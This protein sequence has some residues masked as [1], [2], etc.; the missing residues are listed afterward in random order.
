MLASRSIA[1]YVVLTRICSFNA[2]KLHLVGSIQCALVP[3][4]LKYDMHEAA[5]LERSRP[6]GTETV[7]L[8]LCSSSMI[9]QYH[10]RACFPST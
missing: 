10:W 3:V 5:C 8:R 1:A 6:R 2:S 9:F 4:L 7:P